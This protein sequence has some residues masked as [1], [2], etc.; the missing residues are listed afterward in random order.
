MTVSEY[1]LAVGL[2]EEELAILERCSEGAAI[3]SFSEGETPSIEEGVFLLV[4]DASSS[5][6]SLEALQENILENPAFS[7]L[8]KII[9]TDDLELE[10]SIS[11]ID[12]ESVDLYRK[13]IVEG[14]MR[15]RIKR[16]RDLLRMREQVKADKVAS[17]LVK[18]IFP[19]SPIGIFLSHDGVTFTSGEYADF[20]I[21]PMVEKI[22]GR[23]RREIEKIG[24]AQITHPEDLPEELEKLKRLNAG[25]IGSYT[26]DKRYLRPDGSSVW[27]NVIV[28]SLSLPEENKSL[29]LALITDISEH[30]KMGL[31]LAESENYMSVLLSHLPG[32]AYHCL[33]DADWTMK[34]VS[35]GCFE[36]TGFEIEEIIE[37]KVVSYN[38]II[39]PEYRENLREE[40]E[41]IL[42][43]KGTFKAEYEIFTATGSRKWVMEAAQGVYDEKGKLKS[44]QGIILDVTD[45]KKCEIQLVHYHEYDR[46]TGLPNEWSMEMLLQQ[47]KE[48]NQVGCQALVGIDVSTIYNKNIAYGFAYGQK[49][50]KEIADELKTLRDD[51]HH[52][53]STYEYRFM[54]YV[55]SYSAKEEL[56]SFSEEI[57]RRMRSILRVERIG[58]GIG[59]L[60]L[61]L[62]NNHNTDA[63]LR[64]V[65]VASEKSL[66]SFEEDL[67]FRFF[68]KEMELAL[69][70]ENVIMQELTEI[71]SGK[72]KDRL[73]LEYQAILDL[74][75]D[76]I[77]SFEALA[78]LQSDRF[79]LVS[80]LEFIPLSE[81]SK[82][83]IPLGELIIMKSLL[84]LKRLREEGHDDI[85]IAVNI[86]PVQLLKREFTENLMHMME[87]TQTDPASVCLE[88]TESVFDSTIQEM[89]RLLEE[90]RRLGFSIALD[91]FGTGH[92]S[93]A[94]ETE[95]H[96]C[97][98]KID[99]FF[100]RQLQKFREEETVLS[101]IITMVHKQGLSVIAEGVETE[102]QKQYLR[103][104]G[105]DKI[106]GYLIS[107]PRPEQEVL[108][109]LSD[110]TFSRDNNSRL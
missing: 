106:Q 74:K 18:A 15:V 1:I 102:E 100:I 71:A 32:M 29:Q 51:N 57:S 23:S 7:G 83:I 84:F 33:N 48:S 69:E 58:W 61:D 52:L 6:F 85:T 50:I 20:N 108:K 10:A 80:P 35:D 16:Q 54:F 13:P 94:R 87:T 8:Q 90:L 98:V 25:E 3:L 27:V 104:H 30:K 72:G 4:V 53:F 95:L 78:R 109:M 55:R 49:I 65:L 44:L 31:A 93:L 88:I 91:D 21:N 86:S 19:Q 17:M 47:E 82:L 99:K 36:L 101:S 67:R 22:T 77:C 92:S 41:K 46:R 64:N 73:Y 89:N 42:R 12:D 37:N 39:V 59:I 5:G 56:I 11:R 26:M 40:W 96:V 24:W 75:T 2:H 45:R 107:R 110:N 14:S 60:E 76:T 62:F 103:L 28:F 81:K 97:C 105:C 68:D 70:R 79:G 34:Y 43:K 66:A 63:T 38:D 9:L